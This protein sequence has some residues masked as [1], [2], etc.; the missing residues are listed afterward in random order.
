MHQRR[1]DI[2]SFKIANYFINLKLL[3]PLNESKL[4]QLLQHPPF[5]HKTYIKLNRIKYDIELMQKYIDV[6]FESV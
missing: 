5:I 4:V 1:E 3:K 2:L 6:K